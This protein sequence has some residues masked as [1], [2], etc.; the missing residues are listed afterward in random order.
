MQEFSIHSEITT[1]ESTILPIDLNRFEEV[2]IGL[3]DDDY[4]AKS[5]LSI[6]HGRQHS[7]EYPVRD[8]FD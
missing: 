2:S 1:L 8:N 3:R 5:D 4:R 7:Q 6:I